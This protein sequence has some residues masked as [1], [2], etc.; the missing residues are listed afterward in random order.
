M[1]E[2]S[3]DDPG[4]IDGVSEDL[5]TEWGVRTGSGEIVLSGIGNRE[6]AEAAARRLHGIAVYRVISRWREAPAFVRRRV[7]SR[8][9]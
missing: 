7:N 8:R 5:T 4:A 9:K 2:R 3:G 6:P 1:D